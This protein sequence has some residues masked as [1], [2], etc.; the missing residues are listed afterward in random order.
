[1]IPRSRRNISQASLLRPAIATLIETNQP[2]I[3]FINSGA[4]AFV[5]F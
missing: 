4:A 1:M 5:T 2:P 3:H